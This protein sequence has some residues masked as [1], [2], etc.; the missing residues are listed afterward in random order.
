[1]TTALPAIVTPEE[2][3]AAREALLVKE[4]R[5]TKAMDAVSAER[6]RLPMVAFDKEYE[7][8]GRHGKAALLDVFEGRKQLIVYHFMLHPG[9]DHLCPG[10]SLVLDNMGHPAHLHAR[11]T[12]LAVIAPAPLPEA[13]AVKK[14]MGWTVPWYSSDGTDFTEDCGVGTGF[15]VSVFLRDGDRVF[16]TYFTTGRGGDQLD[17]TLRYLD[18]TPMGRQEDWEE[19]GRGRDDPA[20]SWWRPHDEY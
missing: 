7:F 13:E 17:T 4:K 9:S 6:R 19:S 18:L 2:W 11:D 14:R 20:S 10:C 16:R 15:G 5:L 12:T 3:Q 1:M 8:D